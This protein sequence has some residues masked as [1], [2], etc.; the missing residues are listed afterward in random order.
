M[1]YK[2][3][4]QT[5]AFLVTTDSQTIS[6]WQEAIARKASLF[7]GWPALQ[8]KHSNFAPCTVVH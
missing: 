3:V 1:L 6:K 2:P 8:I 4:N 5:D 7:R